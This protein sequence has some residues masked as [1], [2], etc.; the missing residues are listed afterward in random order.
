MKKAAMALFVALAM[1]VTTFGVVETAYA[2]QQPAADTS[3]NPSHTKM[4]KKK[5]YRRKKKTGTPSGSVVSNQF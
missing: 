1:G 2:Q 4:K 5:K 3:S